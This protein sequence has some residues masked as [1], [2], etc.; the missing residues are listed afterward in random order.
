MK[1]VSFTAN[2]VNDFLRFDIKFY[3]EIT[4]LIGI[5][6]SGKTTALKLILGLLS[7]SFTH[8]N[9]IKFKDAKLVIASEYH[10][11]EYRIIANRKGSEIELLLSR[12]EGEDIIDEFTVMQSESSSFDNQDELSAERF[13]RLSE[14]FNELEVVKNIRALIT[15]IFLGL[16]RRIYEGKIIDRQRAIY[17]RTARSAYNR[18]RLS[19]LNSLNRGLVDVVDLIYDFHRRI[20][21]RQPKITEDFK[22]K[23]LKSSFGFVERGNKEI[24]KNSKS[25]KGKRKKLEEALE[26]IEV[27]ELGEEI[28]EFFDRII[29]T[30]NEVH[31]LE[32]KGNN[33]EYFEV[34]GEWLIN[35]PQISRIDDII[36]YSQ[37]YQS[38]VSELKEPVKRLETIISTFF[39]ES[40]KGLIVAPDG[41]LIVMLPNGKESTVFNLSSGEKQILIMIAH[42]I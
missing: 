16:D 27:V 34:L 22:N 20:G 32:G 42:L 31:R 15:P 23:I 8:L 19:T 5:N 39:S 7:P 11:E 38:Q 30:L 2:G 13:S 10:K 26:E 25:L 41:E 6:G 14:A 40:G 35:S 37:E 12:G 29:H 1:L 33:P 24:P 21:A 36:R 4:F 18:R 17:R 28:K 3:D 9:N